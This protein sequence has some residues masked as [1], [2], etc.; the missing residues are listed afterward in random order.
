ML[1]RSFLGVL[2]ALSGG[3]L[4]AQ[5][6]AHPRLFFDAK[7]IELLRQ[8]I[9]TTHAAQWQAVRRD[10][11][12]YLRSGPPGY[13]APTGPNDEQ[14]W[15]R[16]VGNKLPFLAISYLLVP[17]MTPYLDAAVKWSLASCSYPLWG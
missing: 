10:A 16:E 9:G 2:T 17:E 13:T 15:Q 11:D 7:S 4:S 6:P 14:L 12:S 3:R 5:A 8:R 1:R